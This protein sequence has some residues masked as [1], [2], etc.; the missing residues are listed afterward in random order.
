MNTIKHLMQY[1]T[2]LVDP[3][4]TSFWGSL[5]RPAMRGRFQN[6]EAEIGVINH[7]NS[8]ELFFRILL[9]NPIKVPLFLLDKCPLDSTHRVNLCF[10]KW[11]TIFGFIGPL[12]VNKTIDSL[13]EQNVRE[14][15]RELVETAQKLERGE[16]VL[17]DIIAVQKQ[18][19][20]KAILIVIPV[21]I[22]VVMVIY[23]FL[24]RT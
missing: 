10:G 13:G 11:L 16:I 19:I 7:E 21:S 3:K 2:V 18:D 4:P 1:Q 22:I 5:Y 6:Y 14:N 20:T 17:G 15:F 9:Q 8:S 23:W 24:M 12:G